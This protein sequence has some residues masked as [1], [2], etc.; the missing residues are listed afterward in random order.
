MTSKYNYEKLGE[1]NNKEQP[2]DVNKRPRKLKL[3]RY[4]ND[5]PIYA[6]ETSLRKTNPRLNTVSKIQEAAPVQFVN[7]SPEQIEEE[8]FWDGFEPGNYV[9]FC[10]RRQCER[11]RAYCIN[12]FAS[13]AG[14]Y[15]HVEVCVIDVKVKTY[16]NLYLT[17]QTDGVKFVNHVITDVIDQNGRRIWDF[18]WVKLTSEQVTR[19]KNA[20]YRLAHKDNRRKFSRFNIFCFCLVSMPCY[21]HKDSATAMCTQTTM[22]FIAEV[23][24]GSNLPM[25]ANLY[26][27]TPDQVYHFIESNYA[28]LNVQMKFNNADPNKLLEKV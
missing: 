7:K 24:R 20:I 5:D 23:W 9:I 25:A 13:V 6:Y 1:N 12:K 17:Q 4:D 26:S 15:I 16:K 18:V 19:M 8:E 11:T 2:D 21:C 22:E 28:V 27:Y 3:L 14:E 10:F